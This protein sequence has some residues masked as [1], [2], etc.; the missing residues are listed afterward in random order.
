MTSAAT[1]LQ[2]IRLPEISRAD[3]LLVLSL[4]GPLSLWDFYLGEIRIFDFLGLTMALAVLCLLAPIRNGL[5]LRLDRSATILTFALFSLVLVYSL[6]GIAAH[7]DNLKPSIGMLL[8]AS[9]VV[10]VRGVDLRGR[11]IDDCIRYVA[12]AHLAAFYVQLAY[13]YTTHE[14][15]NYHAVL[16]LQPR[17]V[18]SVF[19]PA[20]LFLEPAIFCFLACSIFLLRRQRQQ[21]F[22]GLDYLL[23]LSMVLSL[24]LW[25]IGVALILFFGFRPRTAVLSALAAAIVLI[26][27]ID[28]EKYLHSP[29]YLFFES[30]LTDLAAD[31]STQGRFAGTLLLLSG[32]LTDPAVILG[33]GI[34]NFFAEYGS[35][36]FSFVVNSFGLIGTLLLVALFLLLAPPRQWLLFGLSIAI[37]LTAA[38]LWKT[39][40]FWLWIAL[41]LLPVDVTARAAAESRPPR[42]A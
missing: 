36:G 34:N 1:A 24:S 12:Y 9:V 19:R 5:A 14:L 39:L 20:G 30:R 41:M 23:L 25:G 3:Y 32:L 37:L 28:I 21:S 17:L 33:Q 18:A 27:F 2:P 4:I 7:P 35:N 38:P 40:Y 8:G 22:S 29:A 10:L 26:L 16:G 42:D 11:A 6:A 15:L 13:F 31:A